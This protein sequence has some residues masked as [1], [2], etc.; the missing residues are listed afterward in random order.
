MNPLM[1][2]M[3]A[4]AGS[5]ALSLS[6]AAGL[7]QSAP[8]QPAA[9][10]TATATTSQVYAHPALWKV[11]DADTTIYLFG[12]IHILPDGVHWFG[13]PV[14]KAFDTSGELVTEIVQPDPAA[15]Q[16]ITMA[17]A[18]RADGKT[19]R[20]TLSPD[21]RAKYEAALA[22]VGTASGQL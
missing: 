22:R 8:A 9:T 12:T 18:L 5:L 20:S 11:S 7:A 15:M 10:T 13:G 17:K 3:T 6:P 16:K 4:F 19:L 21:E 14:Q 2:R 1:I